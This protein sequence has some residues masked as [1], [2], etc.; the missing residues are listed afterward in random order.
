[1]KVLLRKMLKQTVL[2][3]IRNSPKPLNRKFAG[4]HLAAIDAFEKRPTE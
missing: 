4:T 1:M 2:D 3:K